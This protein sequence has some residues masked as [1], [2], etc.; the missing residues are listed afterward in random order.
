[1][2]VEKTERTIAM[3][4]GQITA[5][6]I[7]LPEI[8]RGY[9]WKP[10]QVAKLVESLYRGYPSGSLL[11]WKTEDRP[12]TRAIQSR[13]P[14]AKPVILPLYL[15]DGQ[16]RLTSLHRVFGN[17]PE[18]QIV[19]NVET[20]T[21]QNQ[22]AA[23]KQDPR[24]VRVYDIV[25]PH[26][27]TFKIALGLHQAGVRTDLA[28]I[29]DR[30]TAL[31]NIGNYTYHLEVLSDL[32]YDEVAQIFVRVN[33]GGRALKTT[34]L[35]LATLS[36]RWPGI[37]AKFNDEAKY[38]Y[39]QSYGDINFTFLTRALTGA[40]LGRGLSA[41][42]HGRL[43]ATTDDEL[44]EG[45][46]TVKRGLRHFIPL[47][48][49]NLGITHSG[50]L[51]SLVALLPAVVLLGRRPDEKL[52]TETANGILYWF[53]AAT[54]LGRY[55]G[56]TDSVLGQDIPAA[57]GKDPVRALLT[58]LGLVGSRLKVSEEA[59]LGRTSASPY[60]LLSFL[61]C[62]RAGA[63]DWWH[64]VKISPAAQG[65]QKLEYHHIH[66]KSTLAST[67]A[68]SEINDLANLAFI[69]AK[70]NQI[71]SN[72]TP[73]EYF[74]PLPTDPPPSG[75]AKPK[76][77]SNE[78]ELTSHF[79][80]LDPELRAT[81]HFREFLKA[82]RRLLAVAMTDLLNSFC[83]GW[84]AELTWTPGAST[85]TD[86][87]A[88]VSLALSA[89]ESSWDVGKLRLTAK[90]PDLVWEAVTDLESFGAAIDAA[91]SG[92]DADLEIAGESV[93]ARVDGDDLEIP[94]G[95][96]LVN[97]P[98]QAWKRLLDRSRAEAHPLS[99]C[100]A[101]TIRPWENAPRTKFPLTN[102]D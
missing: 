65:A 13:T 2:A 91:A 64:A 38:W 66:P 24:Y 42:S 44:E 70:A 48:K 94:L 3:L 87:L 22:S 28:V 61:V 59:L 19:F 29:G 99:E 39:K 71:I 11:F 97:G 77:L 53:L 92:L 20:E 86:G 17:N 96:I 51:P 63:E 98:P 69:S 52:D 68:N 6:E 36:A 5:G 37:V 34:D 8:Q 90:T 54:V 43:A 58:N 40:V 27:S 76:R 41:W 75:K 72:R 102:A 80:P 62:R 46:E 16:Q 26:A 74:P 9:V 56:S 83:P 57:S 100:P 45:W 88:G 89:Y 12:G 15:L 50:L 21:F 81:G 55:S 84:L 23:T 1:M 95:P 47:L 101:L 10:T 31:R 60:F 4:V 30:L 73:A 32:P 33:S 35:A 7:R 67:Y 49:E 18:A 82:R 78:A 79:I 85:A 14:R 25:E 93:P